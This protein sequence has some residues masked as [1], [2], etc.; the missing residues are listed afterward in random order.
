MPCHASRC[1]WKGR[2]RHAQPYYGS[3]VHLRPVL[4]GV[5]VA[6]CSG[7][8][9]R[10]PPSWRDE[11]RSRGAVPAAAL[12]GVRPGRIGLLRLLWRTRHRGHGSS[13]ELDVLREAGKPPPTVYARIEFSDYAVPRFRSLDVIVDVYSAESVEGQGLRAEWLQDFDVEPV[14]ANF[15]GEFSA[16]WSGSLSL[17]SSPCTGLPC[18]GC[19]SAR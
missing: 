18:A 6:S 10:P 4:G 12:G 8:A 3:S 9:Q 13:D 19:Q 16:T 1:T 17:A 15:G 7:R 5:N 2:G 14:R 11:E